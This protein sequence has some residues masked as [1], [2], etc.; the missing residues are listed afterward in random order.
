MRISGSP[1]LNYQM[2][3]FHMTL[4]LLNIFYIEDNPD[5]ILLVQ[6]LLSEVPGHNLKLHEH[7]TLS[8]ALEAASRI[9]PDAALLDLNLPD[10]RGL[11]TFQRLSDGHPDLPVVILTVTDLEDVAMQAVRSGAQDYLVKRQLTGPL[12]VRALRY[13][14]ERKAT[15]V[16]LS[17]TRDELE[18][19][20]AER[21]E[22]LVMTNKVLLDEI[23]K[24]VKIQA[25]LTENRRILRMVT[26][27]IPAMLAFVDGQRRLRFV[28]KFYEYAFQRPITEI[29]GARVADIL[30][31]HYPEIQIQEGY[32]LAGQSPRFE[33]TL[34]SSTDNSIR[35]LDITL[36][37]SRGK[38]DTI[39]GYYVLG[40][41]ISER[42]QLEQ[43]NIE[44]KQLLQ[45][46]LD[47]MG[48]AVFFIDVEEFRI[49]RVNR[50]AEE[51][52]G[53]PRARI[54]GSH[55]YDYICVEERKSPEQDCPTMG[56]H[57]LHAEFQLTRPDGAVVPIIKTVLSVTMD[58]RP[59]Q[60]AILIDIT[61]RK[62]MERQLAYAQKL[63]SVGQLAAG[64][65]HEINTPIQYVGSN[66]QFFKSVYDKIIALLEAYQE[67]DACM[68]TGGN[69]FSCRADLRH[70]LEDDDLGELLDEIPQALADALEGVER[71]A[72]IVLAMKKF[73]HPD[74]EERKLFDVNEALLNT[75]TIARNEW[76]YVAEVQTELADDLRRIFA[77][78]GDIN[79]VL[80]NVLVNAAHAIKE[81]LGNSGD[82]GLIV[83]RTRNLDDQVEIQVSDTGCGIPESN[84]QRI[85]DPFYTTK[86]V[87]KGTGQGLAITLAVIT[88][89]GGS[90]DFDSR[91]GEGT[92]F[93][94]RLPVDVENREG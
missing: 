46:I 90:I 75:M 73:S 36:I 92:T 13:A 49:V 45:N 93:I 24:R 15:E 20:V 8:S 41:D 80:L 60:V 17:R 12:L 44:Q 76:K 28:N 63:E 83:M 7:T 18:T 48:A 19:R 86:E 52:L 88:K 81:K 3:E 62:D 27:N 39:N 54:L 66:L 30:G 72:S 57:T 85:F 35:Y 65:A 6:A 23:E 4:D 14:I 22:E 40:H 43:R 37:P 59:H 47:G 50:I 55:C 78:P 94:I 58:G 69:F 79:Q 68:A 84:R 10:S 25:N 87:G 67:L 82:K 77:V 42:K 9:T 51:L 31:E 26:D 21:T 1:W 64:I 71:V 16:S 32:A 61:H 70:I 29:V 74:V 2:H 5:D 91:L 89:H 33:L 53:I 38:G 56:K 11:Q 34:P